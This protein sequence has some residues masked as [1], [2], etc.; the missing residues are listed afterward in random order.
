[1]SRIVEILSLLLIAVAIGV[2]GKSLLLH[3]AHFRTIALVVL[4]A[5]ALIQ[6]AALR[7]GVGPARGT[8]ISLN[9]D[10]VFIAAIVLAFVYVTVPARWS[11]GACIVAIEFGLALE[12]LGKFAPSIPPPS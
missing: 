5:L 7:R 10:V 11:S 12:L 3:V 9:R 2:G 1:M 8:S 6:F 4:A